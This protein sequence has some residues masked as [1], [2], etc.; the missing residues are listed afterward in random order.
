M[1]AHSIRFTR[2][3]DYKPDTDHH[4]DLAKAGW[5]LERVLAVPCFAEI[6][7]PQNG[8]VMLIIRPQS[9]DKLDALYSAV[10]AL[11]DMEL[12][13][14]PNED[15]V[16]LNIETTDPTIRRFM[17]E[18]AKV[19]TTLAATPLLFKNMALLESD[20]IAFTPGKSAPALIAKLGQKY[21]LP[22][23]AA[24]TRVPTHA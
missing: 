19:R 17:A 16:V 21:H 9:P 4:A 23:P 24:P 5:V 2:I 6:C 1:G 10:M 15:A 13:Y 3:A 12:N 11:D 22:A 20:C 18:A 8:A 7:K 14:N